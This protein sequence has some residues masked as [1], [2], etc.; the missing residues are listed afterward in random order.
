[1]HKQKTFDEIVDGIKKL[2]DKGFIPSRRKGD[3]GIGKTLEYELGIPD[4]SFKGPDGVDTELKS[5]RIDSGSMLT[6][7]TKSPLPRGINTKLRIEYGYPDD[8]F[9]NKKVLRTTIN[10]TGFNSIQ[11][12]PDK[13]GFKI[14]SI[15][16]RIEIQASRPPKCIPDMETPYWKK[17]DLAKSVKGKYG[18]SLLYVKA[19]VKTAGENE[20]FHYKEAYHLKGFDS[21]KLFKLL[22]NGIL[23]VDIRLGL[24][25]DGRYHDHGTGIRIKPRL[26]DECFS[27]KVQVV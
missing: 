15:G 13:V 18:D 27:Y 26:I 21:D 14:T 2:K 11:K 22:A 5:G 24:Y 1:M 12:S 9:K 20:L 3:T 23:D 17:E 8:N 25:D 16:D 7:F 4:N 10:A 6:L 19:D